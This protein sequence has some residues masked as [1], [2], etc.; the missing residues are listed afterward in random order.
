MSAI[1]EGAIQIR[2]LLADGKPFFV[3]RNGTIEIEVLFFWN[4]HRPARTYPDS[5][6]LQIERNAGIFPATDK[7]IDRWCEEYVRILGLMDG[8]AAGWYTPT[9]HIEKAILDQRAPGAFRTPLRSLEPYYVEA[10]ARW[11][12]KLAGKKV[13]VVSSF[14]DTIQRQLTKPIWP[15]GL[16]D[17]SGV[18]WSFVRTG[19]APVTAAGIAE[20]P[21]DCTTWEEAVDY[22][23]LEV[24]RRGPEVALIGCGGLGMIIAGRLRKLGISAI[25]LG[26]SI[27]VLFGIKGRRWARHDV[28]SGFWNDAWVSPAAH[29]V[30]GAFT[31]IEGGCYW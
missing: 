3:G 12:E 8:G 29:E 6:R 14:T 2:K 7:S 23:V 4:L 13:T 31:K 18:D 21:D 27:Q 15:N 1:L 5:I 30:P 26:G 10:G 9:A 16:L 11:T 24:S 22:V 20:W 28:I 17:I 25:V 19:Y